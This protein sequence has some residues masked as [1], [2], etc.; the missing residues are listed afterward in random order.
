MFVAT[1][2]KTRTASVLLPLTQ[3]LIPIIL[4]SSSKSNDANEH[5]GTGEN[6]VTLES[7]DTASVGFLNGTNKKFDL[8][9]DIPF[10][11]LMDHGFI[12]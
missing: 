6:D 10:E 5:L 1:V 7:I 12:W 2:T 4:A 3:I 9:I 11:L 8:N